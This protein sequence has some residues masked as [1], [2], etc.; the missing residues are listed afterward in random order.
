MDQYIY[1]ATNR[2]LILQFM[3][4]AYIL[5]QVRKWYTVEIPVGGDGDSRLPNCGDSAVTSMRKWSPQAMGMGYQSVKTV[6]AV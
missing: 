6:H 5:T 3:H 2:K 1:M 4:Q